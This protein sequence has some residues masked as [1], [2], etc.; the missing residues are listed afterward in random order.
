MVVEEDTIA[1]IATARGEASVGIIRV[2]GPQAAELVRKVFRL[3][4][5][6]PCNLSSSR[7]LLYGTLVN[8]RSGEAVDEVMLLWMPGPRSYTAEDVAELQVHGGIQVVDAGLEVVLQA[9]ARLADPG[10]FTKRA[11]LNGRIDLSQAEAVIDLIRAKTDL[12]ARSALQQ[13][14]GHFGETIRALRKR[15]LSLQAHVEVT[16]DYPEHDVESVALAQVSEVGSE[17]LGK[18]EELIQSAAVGRILR[19][20]VYT[21]IVGRPNVGKSSLL[22]ALLRRERAIVTDIPGTTRD[23][24]E[25]YI[26]IR[27]IPLRLADTAGIRETE[28]VVEQIGVKRSR[29]ALQEAELALLVLNG[30]E[31]LSQDDVDL[32]R[33]SEGLRRVIAINK[34]DLGLAVE[35]EKVAEFAGDSPVVQISAKKMDGL[36]MLEETIEKLV[37]GSELSSA[38]IGYSTNA[39]QAKLLSEAKSDLEVALSAAA[40]GATLDIIAVQ[41]QSVYA[42]LGLAIGEE[43]GEDLLDEIFSNFCLGK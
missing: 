35:L 24:V 42:L 39:R 40:Q 23:V 36:A 1:A 22:N 33:M 7:Q 30:S 41:L 31:P 4:S 27:G 26:N 15:L 6:A 2:S 29:E 43:A 12:A 9:G 38:E 14:K 17:L 8:S 19:E 10:E 28:D 11:F 5:G 34:A 18:I 3:P 20:G 13:V 37:L 21:A 32:L 16:M 25:E